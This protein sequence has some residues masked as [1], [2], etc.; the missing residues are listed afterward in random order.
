MICLKLTR[1]QTINQRTCK[2]VEVDILGITF[3]TIQTGICSVHL[4]EVSLFFCVFFFFFFSTHIL[5]SNKNKMS[6]DRRAHLNLCFVYHKNLFQLC[7][8]DLGSRTMSLKQDITHHI[9]DKQSPS[10]FRTA[11][12]PKSRPVQK[13]TC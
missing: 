10:T 3:G 12:V 7:G 1:C 9:Y 6:P 8:L 4:L 2:G 11:P 13:Q 5:Q